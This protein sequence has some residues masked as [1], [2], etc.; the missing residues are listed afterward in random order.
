ML[1]KSKVKMLTDAVNYTGT[2]SSV[3]EILNITECNV[4]QAAIIIDD[5]NAIY[6]Q[7]SAIRQC[8]GSAGSTAVTADSSN[9]N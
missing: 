5:R 8:S 7:S 6:R 1:H 4:V 3:N 9:T 2:K